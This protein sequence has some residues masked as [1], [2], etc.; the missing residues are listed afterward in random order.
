MH[1][2]VRPA[3]VTQNI[4]RLTVST[5]A[6][7]HTFSA[8]MH[9]RASVREDESDSKMV[10]EMITF[11]RTGCQVTQQRMWDSRYH[12]Q[13]KETDKTYK[14]LF[15]VSPAFTPGLH[16][17]QHATGTGCVEDRS[18]PWGG[19]RACEIAACNGRGPCGRL[20][21]GGQARS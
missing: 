8:L 19:L 18:C 16:A 2:L 20:Q 17:G 7:L 11:A 5:L 21:L 3:C 9:E 1:I 10:N 4:S 14:S 6:R 12:I 13:N 15:G